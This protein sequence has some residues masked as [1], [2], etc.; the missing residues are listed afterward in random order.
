[1]PGLSSCRGH[2]FAHRSVDLFLHLHGPLQIGSVEHHGS[3][4]H[5]V[6]H[7]VDAPRRLVEIEALAEGMQFVEL[8]GIEPVLDGHRALQGKVLVFLEG[9]VLEADALEGIDILLPELLEQ[10]LYVGLHHPGITGAPPLVVAAQVGKVEVV[11]AVVHQVARETGG[12]QV[13]A[14]V[15]DIG[16]GDVQLLAFGALLDSELVLLVGSFR[17]HPLLDRRQLHYLRGGYR[18]TLAGRLGRFYHHTLRA[19]TGVSK[20]SSST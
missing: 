10:Q 11:V 15:G 16:Q 3:H 6:L 13:L 19:S 2:R 7:Q 5:I 20:P 4:G 18:G 9:D 12:V 1:M 17:S 14:L 8:G